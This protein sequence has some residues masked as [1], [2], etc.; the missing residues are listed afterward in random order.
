MKERGLQMFQLHAK[1]TSGKSM[2]KVDDHFYFEYDIVPNGFGGYHPV[3][4]WLMNTYPFKRNRQITDS[5]GNF[6]NFPGI[7]KGD[8]M[9]K[10]DGKLYTAVR[11][12]FL[13]S[14]IKHGIIYVIWT[15]QPDGRYF[16]DSDGFGS[17]NFSEIRL[18][19]KMNKK[20]DFICPFSEQRSEEHGFCSNL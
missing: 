5:C 4:I 19:S 7:S 16:E 12:T 13:V 11:F 14:K 15:V 17:E 18:Y 1:H 9:K 6:I 10:L 2:K 8:W 3:N 20:G